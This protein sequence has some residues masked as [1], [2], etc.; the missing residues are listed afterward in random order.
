MLESHTQCIESLASDPMERNVPIYVNSI[1]MNTIKYYIGEEN[2]I[3][4]SACA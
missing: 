3:A 1:I 4:I 2:F